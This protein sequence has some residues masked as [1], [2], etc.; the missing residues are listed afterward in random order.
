MAQPERPTMAETNI[1]PIAPPVP[2]SP[3]VEG[4]VIN[5]VSPKAPLTDEQRLN[6]SLSEEDRLVKAGGYLQTELTKEQK[7]TILKAHYQEQLSQ[8]VKTLKEGGFTKEQRRLLVEKHIAGVLDPDEFATFN[9]AVYTGTPLEGIAEELADIGGASGADEVYLQGTADRVRR[10][11]DDG[12]VP[13]AGAKDLLLTVNKW[14]ID[15]AN[16]RPDKR[17]ERSTTSPSIFEQAVTEIDNLEK[18]ILTMSAGPARVVAETSLVNLRQERDAILLEIRNLG[19]F[20]DVKE[21]VFK[22][23]LESR[24]EVTFRE[25]NERR[26]DGR[27]SV[28]DNLKATQNTANTT[29]WE[30]S[31]KFWK[32][33]H[34]QTDLQRLGGINRIGG[35]IDYFER[36]S[37]KL[38][39]EVVVDRKKYD[40]PYNSVDYPDRGIVQLWNYTYK[41]I[42]G[43]SYEATN[44]T[45][46]RDI[47]EH[48]RKTK[49]KV[50]NRGDYESWIALVA[51]DP[52]EAE[53]MLPYIVGSVRGKL[54]G[55]PQ[56]Q[57]STL[58]Q[59]QEK[60]VKAV[61]YLRN[62]LRYENGDPK[63]I[64]LATMV[65]QELNLLGIEVFSDL[66]KETWEPYLQYA[67]DI[68]RGFKDTEFQDHTI[69]VLLLDR[70]GIKLAAL[71][72]MALNDWE[73]FRFGR[74]TKDTPN[75][76]EYGDALR[77]QQERRVQ[78]EDW[79]IR[80][81][82]K[83]MDV[84]LNA[85]VKADGQVVEN[86]NPTHPAFQRMKDEL[87][88]LDLADPQHTVSGFVSRWKEYVSKAIHWQRTGESSDPRDKIQRVI[89]QHPLARA[90]RPA[91]FTDE[92]GNVTVSDEFW[93]MFRQV[94]IQ[95]PVK[96]DRWLKERRGIVERDLKSAERI[97]KFSMSDVIAGG[98]RHTFDVYE[99]NNVLSS[100]H[101][102]IITN[103][104]GQQLLKLPTGAELRIER[105]SNG[106]PVVNEVEPHMKML[107]DLMDRIFE[108]DGRKPTKRRL[109][110]LYRVLKN[111][112]GID[113]PLPGF[114]DWYLGAHDSNRPHLLKYLK[115][116]PEWKEQ[117]EERAKLREFDGTEGNDG[118][119]YGADAKT[120]MARDP[121]DGRRLRIL[122][123]IYIK[124][125]FNKHFNYPGQDDPEG[126][127]KEFKN[128][129]YQVYGISGGT[130]R[131]NA[132]IKSAWL[133]EVDPLGAFGCETW[134]QFIGR[135]KG[136]NE[137]VYVRTR[138]F[139]V[140][141]RDAENY[142]KRFT[143]MVSQAELW[144]KGKEDSEGMLDSSPIGGA[145][146]TRALNKDPNSFLSTN[147]ETWKTALLDPMKGM[148]ELL[149][150][151][152]YKAYVEVSARVAGPMAKIMH[153]RQKL[154]NVYGKSPQS[155]MFLN[156][157]LWYD[158]L[159]W[160]D[161]SPEEFRSKF[162]FAY[163][164][165]LPM[166]RIFIHTFLYES[167][168]IYNDEQFD[169][170]MLGYTIPKDQWEA[171]KSWSGNP[172]TKP[173]LNSVLKNNTKLDRVDK[174]IRYNADPDGKA[175]GY[176][177]VRDKATGQEEWKYNPNSNHVEDGEI[178]EGLLDALP[179]EI[180]TE[181]LVNRWIPVGMNSYLPETL[182][183][184]IQ[185]LPNE[186]TRNKTIY[187]NMLEVVK[188]DIANSND[189]NYKPKIVKKRRRI[190]RP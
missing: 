140:N 167:G 187:Q 110:K 128:V 127:I 169:R 49:P 1:A 74:N 178:V 166:A 48:E 72:L 24:V 43:T 158:V 76:L 146:T 114:S 44:F 3:R 118:Y 116:V 132:L 20:N 77:I 29:S 149:T 168:L 107:R 150:E 123:E 47:V 97:V 130:S 121:E 41:P 57:S 52:E 19:W 82:L 27:P 142:E 90:F 33:P 45:N 31:V 21:S 104:Q 106:K 161:E 56:S 98:P 17:V 144:T 103:T 129:I 9:K 64:R 102:E 113:S 134:K 179:P 50:P 126:G 185:F 4:P 85:D 58:Q 147:T 30:K 70:K 141:P 115:Q 6:A 188:K 153:A 108:A 138:G 120:A 186:G 54:V 80:N 125:K 81:E 151:P 67:T 55:S 99:D 190:D 171:I 145:F 176:G 131:I 42:S 53:E 94:N 83:P 184:L 95:D 8:K 22:T 122:A 40:D 65:R 84:L 66:V 133:G 88:A 71:E 135:L 16:Q 175:V 78:I 39:N 143:A 35:V 105:D 2:T 61:D 124:N 139:F 63:F 11:V 182:N 93:E 155:A 73:Y 111:K 180:R 160:M 152:A 10:M 5:Q 28:I 36:E 18:Q 32:N 34:R 87:D 26:M 173:Q 162:G 136:S 7:D 172:A 117:L 91:G 189:P 25:K 137:I 60:W 12:R 100:P 92:Q 13:Y 37:L 109:M 170:V 163:D 101:G 119:G 51:D 86:G 38:V 156:T 68:A 164:V 89:F 181:A 177:R 112:L 79:L 15:A 62:E 14:R 183:A 154:E 96:S 69:D 46:V 148:D 174:L 165:N 157:I 159:K 59:E 75:T 23:F